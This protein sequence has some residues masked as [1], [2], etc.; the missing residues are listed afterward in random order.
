[1]ENVM[2]E[3]G[4]E[5]KEELAQTLAKE[6]L[7]MEAFRKQLLLVYIPEFVKSREVRSHISLDTGEIESYYEAHKNELTSKPS[8]NLQ[9]IL[10]SKDRISSEDATNLAG[11]IARQFAAGRTFG[12]LAA[13]Y[14]H[15]SS[16]SNEGNAG[17]YEY[18][19]L[20]SDLSDVVLETPEGKITPLLPTSAGWYIFLVKERR[21]PAVPT[22][23]E[24]REKIVA[25]LQEEKFQEVYENYLDELREENYVRINP[26]YI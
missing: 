5:T 7:T 6:G 1:V 26:K 3:Y 25:I 21:M 9:E 14:S 20:S 8:V 13:L 19:D 23:E 24:S 16:R 17:W 11:E 18:A 2:Q 12:E 10:L 22:L 4:M 15:A